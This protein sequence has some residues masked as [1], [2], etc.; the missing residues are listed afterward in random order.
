MKT[1]VKIL[2]VDDH[3]MLLHGLR[4]AISRQPGFS[5]AG[6][7]STG[8]AAL[9]LALQLVPDLIVMDVYLPDMD[10]IDATRRILAALPSVKIVIFSGDSSRSLIDR[11][12]EAGAVGFVP[13]EGSVEELMHAIDFVMNGKVYVSPELSTAI[14]EDYRKDLMGG[15]ALSKPPLSDL[16]TQL[17]KLVAEG[18][19]NKEIASELGA[20]VKSVEAHRSRLARKLGCS[21]SAEMVRYA[22]RERIIAA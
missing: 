2:L 9:D 13:K 19:R 14:L 6:E 18:Q 4:L 3:P 15:G 12:L 22:I 16:E 17:L 7:A 8:S 20:T 5:L 1:S 21:S 10:G 11:S